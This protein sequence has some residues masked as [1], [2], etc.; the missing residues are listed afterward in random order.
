MRCCNTGIA[1]SGGCVATTAAAR[2]AHF[3]IR[4]RF[5]CAA[6]ATRRHVCRGLA[7]V[8]SAGNRQCRTPFPTRGWRVGVRRRLRS[9]RRLA[10]MRDGDGDGHSSSNRY[11]TRPSMCRP[12]D[13]SFLRPAEPGRHATRP[14]RT[15]RTR[16]QLTSST[17][18]HCTRPTGGANTRQG[19][20]ATSVVSRRPMAPSHVSRG[21]LRN[22]HNDGAPLT[23][24]RHLSLRWSVVVWSMRAPSQYAFSPGSFPAPRRAFHPSAACCPSLRG[25]RNRQCPASPVPAARHR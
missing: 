17:T 6:G 10:G 15:G 12:A 20:G 21:R 14:L 2:P 19:K 8:V 16:H 9:S 13:R 25:D 11:T 7:P 24:V 1:T 23:L 5:G 18:D 3:S 22:R 4:H